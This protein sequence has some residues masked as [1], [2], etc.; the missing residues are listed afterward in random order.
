LR[1]SLGKL[2]A[3]ALGAGAAVLLPIAAQADVLPSGAQP[4]GIRTVDIQSYAASGT[5]LTV[6]FWGGLCDIYSATAT[7][8]GDKVTVQVTGTPN[9][10]GEVCPMIAK[11]FTN[12]VQ[13][14]QP[15]GARQVIDAWDGSTIT[16]GANAK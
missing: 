7:E 14:N 12:T 2:A 15:L 11:Q 8:S 9:K 4:T 16:P 5:T 13:L 3:A 10:P 6:R 1:S